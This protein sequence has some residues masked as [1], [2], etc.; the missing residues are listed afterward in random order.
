MTNKKDAKGNLAADSY[1]ITR[2]GRF[3]RLTSLDELPQL[4]NVIKGDLSLVGPRPLLEEY[5]P[6]YN[7]QQKRR[8]LI[9][10]GMTG[11]AQV[12]GR[13]AIS[14]EDRFK[15]DI[16]YVERVSFLL[17]LKIFCLT[18]KKILFHEDIN[19][20]KSVTMEKFQGNK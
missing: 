4:I 9:K 11:W 7:E 8:H 6:L 13:N 20:S 15:Y 3:L 2:F 17:D 18:L 12:I 1:R 16:Y 10:P 19:S 14:S 5:L